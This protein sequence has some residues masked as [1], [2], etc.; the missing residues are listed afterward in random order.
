[1]FSRLH[2]LK[3]ASASALAEPWSWEVLSDWI[4]G[5]LKMKPHNVH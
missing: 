4:S 2:H 3:E 5:A 1:M